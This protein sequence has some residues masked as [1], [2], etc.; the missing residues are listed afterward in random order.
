[1]HYL[2]PIKKAVF[3]KSRAFNLP[4]KL[5]ERKDSGKSVSRESQR[6]IPVH[7]LKSFVSKE[8]PIIQ[9]LEHILAAFQAPHEFPVCLDE[10]GCL[11][12]SYQE[13][14]MLRSSAALSQ[15][16]S[17]FRIVSNIFDMLS[18]RYG[19]KYVNNDLIAI[20]ACIADCMQN[21]LELGNWQEANRKQ[22]AALQKFLQ[23][24]LQRICDCRE[25]R[26]HLENNLDLKFEDMISVILC[27]HLK[28][29]NRMQDL[30]KRICIIIAHG[31][32]TASSLADAVN[33]SGAL[34]L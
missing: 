22:M 3:W 28:L 18:L 7:E 24:S 4:E 26:E 27:L 32:S 17:M 10:A 5:R 30:N 16:M 25:I 14:T 19:F 8:R 2:H 15:E 6:M 11:M 9:L 31:F 34:C 33:I 23:G 13:A 21:T 12:H 20:T 29:L 1:M